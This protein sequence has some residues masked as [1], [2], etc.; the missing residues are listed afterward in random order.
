MDSTPEVTQ[1]NDVIGSGEM[2]NLSPKLLKYL[3]DQD[4]N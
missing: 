4:D 3:K 2:K 1:Q